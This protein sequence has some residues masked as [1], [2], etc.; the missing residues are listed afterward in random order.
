MAEQRGGD[1]DT[2]SWASREGVHMLGEEKGD[3][4]YVSVNMVLVPP[5][6]AHIDTSLDGAV[7]EE[8]SILGIGRGNLFI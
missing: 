7:K 1:M 2:H 4:L 3:S 8:V 6:V 5:V